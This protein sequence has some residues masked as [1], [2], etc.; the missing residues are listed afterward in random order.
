MRKG[1]VEFNF[2]CNESDVRF[3]KQLVLKVFSLPRMAVMA[4]ISGLTT[5]MLLGAIDGST[6]TYPILIF[7]SIITL[8]FIYFFLYTIVTRPS[9]LENIEESEGNIY[10]LT[11]HGSN[12][13][14]SINGTTPIPLGIESIRNQF[15]Q[16]TRYCLHIDC[17]ALRTF[18]CIP[19]NEATFDSLYGLA[20]GLEKRKKRLIVIKK[21]GEK[22]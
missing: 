9:L 7:A 6:A 4:V 12:L 8:G 2:S 21:K 18:I 11:I 5:I 19:V 16:D 10:A 13:E 1:D 14:L 22:R 15:W 17:K 20:N 3:M